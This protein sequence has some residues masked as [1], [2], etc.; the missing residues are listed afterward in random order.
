M[1]TKKTYRFAQKQNTFI[2]MQEKK[3]SRTKK[4]KKKSKFMWNN[5]LLTLVKLVKLKKRDNM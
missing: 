1:F 5:L 3:C 2:V 4:A